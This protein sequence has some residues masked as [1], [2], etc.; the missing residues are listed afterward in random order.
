MIKRQKYTKSKINTRTVKIGNTV[1]LEVV[2]V[3]SVKMAVFWD[4]A[5]ILTDGSDELTVSIRNLVQKTE[6]HCRVV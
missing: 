6:R 2:M 5:Q 4:A 1:R 3:M